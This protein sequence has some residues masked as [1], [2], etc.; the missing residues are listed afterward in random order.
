MILSYRYTMLQRHCRAVLDSVR[1]QT[2]DLWR[3][4]LVDD[5]SDDGSIEIL[6]AYA[7]LDSRFVLLQQPEN[8]TL[9]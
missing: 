8:Q 9:R 3:A 4:I 2:C 5:A 1:A 7:K 6:R